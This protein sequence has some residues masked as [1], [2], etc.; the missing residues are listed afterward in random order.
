MAKDV[1]D[2]YYYDE[3]TLNEQLD[4]FGVYEKDGQ[5][6]VHFKPNDN[7]VRFSELAMLLSGKRATPTT[8]ELAQG[9]YALFVSDGSGD[10]TDGSLYA[11]HNDG[12]TIEHAELTADG[13]F[14]DL[15]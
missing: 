5:V 15:A 8:D 4:E 14:T 2:D 11:V 10:G 1:D 13:G 6:H 9:E 12:G 7:T 3:G